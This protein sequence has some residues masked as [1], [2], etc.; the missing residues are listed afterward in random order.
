[1]RNRRAL[2][3]WCI[4]VAV[5][6]WCLVFY[7]QGA[8]AWVMGFSALLSLLILNGIVWFMFRGI[9]L[10]AGASSASGQDSRRRRIAFW[11]GVALVCLG[12]VEVGIEAWYKIKGDRSFEV[13]QLFFGAVNL[14][15]GSYVVV[16]QR[17][18]R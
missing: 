6:A 14:S 7:F 3:Y 9:G 1:M 18:N 15:L 8:P 4:N 5:P 2:F 17:R 11:C 10:S 16:R 12:A 13:L